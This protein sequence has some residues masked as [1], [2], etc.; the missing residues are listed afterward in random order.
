[1]L[2]AMARDQ[3]GAQRVLP[4]PAGLA[5]IHADRRRIAALLATIVLAVIAA[6]VLTQLGTL[7]RSAEAPVV[8]ISALPEPGGGTKDHREPGTHVRFTYVVDDVTYPGL[9]FVPWLDIASRGLKVCVAPDD[10][11]DHQLVSGEVT[12]GAGG[13][14]P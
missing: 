2:G 3:A 10:P 8:V 6:A 14:L 4:R 7:R 11:R 1:M 13:F 5:A 9:A 12:C